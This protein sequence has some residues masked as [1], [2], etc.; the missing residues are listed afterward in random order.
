[1]FKKSAAAEMMASTEAMP[2]HPF[3]PRKPG[4]GKKAAK[5]GAKKA[6]AKKSAKGK[7]A[8]PFLRK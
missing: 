2:A 5:K 6:P 3:P 7:K 1:M 8:P 4:P